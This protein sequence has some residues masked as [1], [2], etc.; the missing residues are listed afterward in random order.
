[1][2][3]EGGEDPAPHNNDSMLQGEDHFD[4]VM[5]ES[6]EEMNR[7]VRQR[8]SQS[9]KDKI[10]EID[11]KTLRNPQVDNDPLFKK[12]KLFLATFTIKADE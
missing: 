3:G 5:Q 10:L 12:L 8:P 11:N 9:V 1:M 2:L 6:E 7:I 4:R